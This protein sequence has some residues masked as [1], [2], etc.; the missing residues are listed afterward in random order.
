MKEQ[1]LAS[2]QTYRDRIDALSLRERALIFAVVLGGIF[3]VANALFSPLFG[4][5]TRLQKELAAMR[6]QTLAV[7]AQTEQMVAERAN[8]D[9]I[10]QRRLIELQHQ[11]QKA[12]G[13][14]EGSA[15]GVVSPREM[16]RLV[17]Q[18]LAKDR[19]V[20]VV[21]VENVAPVSLTGETALAASGVSQP[22]IY[23][24]GI[25]IELQGQYLELMR[26]LRAL[27]ALPWKVFWGEVQL[28]SDTHPVLRATVVIYTLSLDR[29][30]I[31]V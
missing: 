14:G 26:Y 5:Q 31:G 18:M 22:V 7:Q 1:L 3:A 9:G 12:G 13:A 23:K 4:Q 19:S 10:N 8:P 17:Q 11:L 24:H 15:R 27:E 2:W 30:W 25:R 20:L 6:A 21:S 28:H 29:A 16:A